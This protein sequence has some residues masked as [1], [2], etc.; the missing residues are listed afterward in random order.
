MVSICPSSRGWR[1]RNVLKAKDF[2]LVADVVLP[3]CTMSV[4]SGRLSVAISDLHS[5]PVLELG[6]RSEMQVVW[7]YR[8][9]SLLLLILSVSGDE[10][11]QSV[12]V[13]GC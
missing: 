8:P 9:R 5:N 3:L 1:S 10:V 7:C 11:D 4:V 13:W 2:E 6:T 12:V